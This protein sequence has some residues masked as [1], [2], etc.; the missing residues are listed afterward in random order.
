MFEKGDKV[1]YKGKEY[2]ILKVDIDHLF[3]FNYYLIT[4][5]ESRFTVLEHEINGLIPNKV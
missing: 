4:D 2:S 5:G 3:L 1:T